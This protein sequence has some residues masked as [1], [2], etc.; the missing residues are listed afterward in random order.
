M[1]KPEGVGSLLERNRMHE[2]VLLSGRKMLGKSIMKELGWPWKK[3]IY[4][5]DKQHIP[6]YLHSIS[7][8]IHTFILLWSRF[9]PESIARASELDTICRRVSVYPRFSEHGIATGR[10]S[11]HQWHFSWVP[12]IS[13]L[14]H[15]K[16]SLLA[17]SKHKEQC[18]ECTATTWLTSYSVS[19]GGV[20]NCMWVVDSAGKY[21][22]MLKKFSDGL[23]LQYLL[24]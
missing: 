6:V 2:T 19:V 18:P 8:Q 7:H 12:G 23:Q 9:N 5:G 24:Y 17:M 1:K 15:L 13:L 21:F 10:L 14:Q 22:I 3:Q 11:L 20:Y 4:K 16:T